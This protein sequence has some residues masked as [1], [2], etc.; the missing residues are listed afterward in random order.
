[1]SSPTPNGNNNNGDHG[2]TTASPIWPQIVGICAGVLL[3]I[4]IVVFGAVRWRKIQQQRKEDEKKKDLDGQTRNQIVSNGAGGDNASEIMP[5]NNSV[6][7]LLP[8][9]QHRH[10]GAPH[11]GHGA[12]NMNVNNGS[13]PP[14]TQPY[15][16]IPQP[17]PSNSPYATHMQMPGASSS[18]SSNQATAVN[19]PMTSTTAPIDTKYDP[20]E[21][22]L[23]PASLGQQ[24]N[25]MHN[26]DMGAMGMGMKF[27]SSADDLV[28]P[29]AYTSFARRR[30]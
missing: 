4:V 21:S 25:V 18:S 22:Q 23:F 17:S 9:G 3:V 12:M 28:D 16:P 5:S 6:Q 26:M 8:H 11:H 2:N 27:H 14:G 29:P 10:H 24:Q 13:Y 19:S 30:E 1:S 15:L 7:S 20:E